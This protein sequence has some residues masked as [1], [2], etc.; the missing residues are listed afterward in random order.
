MKCDFT[1]GC[2]RELVDG[3]CSIHGN[4]RAWGPSQTF[5][6]LTERI[7]NGY[8]DGTDFSVR[9]VFSTLEKAKEA[10]EKEHPN[11][12]VGHV[13]DGPYHGRFEV[14]AQGGIGSAFDSY[15]DYQTVELDK[16]MD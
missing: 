13:I 15:Y 9:G 1:G 4:N 12:S 16:L 11:R 2:D 10:L 3:F 5:I 7:D 8:S 6:L 14:L